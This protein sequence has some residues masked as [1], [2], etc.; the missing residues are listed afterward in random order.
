MKPR[1]KKDG[2]NRLVRW[3]FYSLLFLMNRSLWGGDYAAA[4]LEIGVG[5]RALGMGGAFCSVVDDGTAFYW[6]PAGL[7]FI[8]KP[9]L[10]GMYGPQF[11]SVKNPLGNYHFLG[12]V[13]P[14]PRNAVLAVNWIR[15]SV[16]EIPIYSELQG[17]TY[18]DRLHDISLRPSGEPEG[19]IA[20]KED[21]VYFS[22]ALMNR[23]DVDLGWSYHRVVVEVPFGVNL[24]WIRQ[25]LGDGEASG[26]GLDVGT[27]IRFHLDRFFEI[28][29]LGILSWG[30][31]LQDVTRTKLSWNTRHQDSV[32]MNVKWGVSYRQPLSGIRGYVC[33]S[34]D[35]DSRWDGRNHWGLEYS[36]FQIFGMRVGFDQGEFTAGVG[37]RFWIFRVD[38]A[39]LSHELD[40]LHRMSCSISF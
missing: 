2:F 13:H 17:D 20:D 35:H 5:A 11:G 18:W 3:V 32:P 30:F 25:S 23:W 29:K 12:Y 31:H 39:F 26:L 16:D 40:S 22:F 34:H 38:Y 33:L 36:G 14:L 8:K 1:N 15:L 9:Q 6:N 27:M 28:E 7:A 10:S 21:A 4:F 24:K 19:F 37:L